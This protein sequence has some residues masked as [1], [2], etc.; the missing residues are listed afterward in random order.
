[1][2]NALPVGFLLLLPISAEAAEWSAGGSAMDSAM[3]SAQG[4]TESSVEGSTESSMESST[5]SSMESSAQSSVESSMESSAEASDPSTMPIP[6]RADVSVDRP[7][8]RRRGFRDWIYRWAPERNMAELGA[9]G[10]AYQTG[11]NHELFEPDDSLPDQGFQTF[12]PVAGEL[13][14]R[15][16]FFPSRY[17]GFEVEGGAMP[18][19]TSAFERATLWHT[20][21]SVVGQVGRWSLTPFA[22]VGAGALGVRSSRAAVGNDVDPSV[23]FGGGLKAYINRRA[24]VR[25]DLRDVVSHQQG[26]NEGFRNHSFEALVGVSLTLGRET[27]EVG[28]VCAVSDSDGDGLLDI[29]D[30]CVHE[31]GEDP[32]GCPMRDSDGDGFLDHNDQCVD[33]P[34]LIPNGCPIRDSD[35]DG[36]ADPVDR[37]IEQPENANGFEDSDGC[38]E[39]LP[40]E[41]ADLNG[42]M[43]GIRFQMEKSII[44]AR[45][46]PWLDRMVEL[47]QRYPDIRVEISGHTDDRGGHDYNVGLSL[48]RANAVR[49]YMVSHGVDAG[50]IQTRGVGPTEPIANNNTERGRARNRRIELRV[51]ITPNVE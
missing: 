24:Q 43:E 10:G 4:S 32:Y 45:S 40:Q 46:R 39:Q 5:E 7:R 27:H 44:L 18:T 23:H 35:A 51:L 12:S 8:P 34:G 9:Y 13:G 25:V 37:C 48:R 49:D 38:P 17:F 20:R 33:E 15:L 6:P 11:G 42:V 29:E 21:A 1:M 47:M 3:D 41:L 26:V 28:S 19:E 22:L 2:T 36:V 14:A 31:Y 50:R 16:G 30:K